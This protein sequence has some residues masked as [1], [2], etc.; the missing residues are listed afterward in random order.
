MS[1]DKDWTQGFAT[2]VDDDTEMVKLSFYSDD[3]PHEVLL[4]I[5]DVGELIT[6]LMYL[7]KQLTR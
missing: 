1:F 3:E 6:E 5:Q 7:K 4:D 2:S